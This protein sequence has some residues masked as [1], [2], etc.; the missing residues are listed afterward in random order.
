MMGRVGSS[1]IFMLKIQRQMDTLVR[2]FWT[3]LLVVAAVGLNSCDSAA[4][5]EGGSYDYTARSNGGEV[6]VTGTLDL[7]YS[8]SVAAD[9]TVA[10]TG[11]WDLQRRGPGEDVGPQVGEGDLDG[12]VDSDGN[13][14]INLNPDWADN[15]VFLSGSFSGEQFGDFEGTWSYS[16]FI[17]HTNGGTFTAVRR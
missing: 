16:T 8:E 10:I 14:W 11:H 5:R 13:V 3:F 17:G 1:Q 15:N 12:T 2:R 9:G 6:L 4:L 7:D